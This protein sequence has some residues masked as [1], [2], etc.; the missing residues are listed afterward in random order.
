MCSINQITSI[1]QVLGSKNLIFWLQW[2]LCF[3]FERFFRSYEGQ[4]VPG[5]VGQHARLE[6]LGEKIL[7]N[8][9]EF[10]K[11]P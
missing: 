3:L 10:K 8:L 4:N 2:I 7:P 11:L 9:H 5:L 1:N 6:K